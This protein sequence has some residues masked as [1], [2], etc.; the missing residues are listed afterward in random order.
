MLTFNYQS[1]RERHFAL[2]PDGRKAC[3]KKVYYTCK[4]NTFMTQPFFYMNVPKI[5]HTEGVRPRLM[6]YLELLTLCALPF[7][8]PKTE[9]LEKRLLIDD[10]IFFCSNKE[11]GFNLPSSVVQERKSAFLYERPEVY[12]AC[13]LF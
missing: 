10:E 4:S 12:K 5:L 13:P 11:L 6:V 2:K 9:K 7:S 1:T 8:S 3:Y